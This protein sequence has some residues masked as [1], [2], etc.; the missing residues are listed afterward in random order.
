M[1]ELEKYALDPSSP[2]YESVRAKLDLLMT[3]L[4][5]I[6][7]IYLLNGDINVFINAIFN[8]YSGV[9]AGVKPEYTEKVHA[10]CLEMAQKIRAETMK[11][12]AESGGTVSH[13]VN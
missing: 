5:V 10:D 7:H 4:E 1:P 3:Q 11:E 13:A 2:E 9:L 8:K 6:Q 12:L